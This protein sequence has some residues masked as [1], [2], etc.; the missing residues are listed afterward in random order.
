MG[1]ALSFLAGQEAQVDAIAPFYGTPDPKLA[2]V[3]K[4]LGSVHAYFH[5]L[6]KSLYIL[7]ACWMQPGRCKAPAALETGDH[8][9]SL[10]CMVKLHDQ[11]QRCSRHTRLLY[12]QPATSLRELA[13]QCCS[14][15]RQYR[16][17]SSRIAAKLACP[18]PCRLRRS[19]CQSRVTAERM[20][21]SRALLIRR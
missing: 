20:T 17:A 1:G 9:L 2:K 14:M 3:T 18:G 7:G 10:S 13:C 19:A 11:L 6:A 8:I 16:D 4:W 21:S 5:S 15:R 12:L